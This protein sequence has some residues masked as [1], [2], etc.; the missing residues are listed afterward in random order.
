MLI[1]C[2]NGRMLWL[3]LKLL[4]FQNW[5]GLCGIPQLRF[6]QRC[7]T[8]CVV[9]EVSSF[10]LPGV[11]PPCHSIPASIPTT[12]KLMVPQELQLST[13]EEQE[14]IHSSLMDPLG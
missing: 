8:L 3:L 2:C 5:K 10:L 12:T 4:L 6:W 9:E 13:L 7:E 11:Y 1:H 14:V